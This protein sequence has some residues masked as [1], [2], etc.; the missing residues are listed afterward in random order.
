MNANNVAHISNTRSACLVTR[1][2]DLDSNHCWHQVAGSLLSHE[3][4]R[5][6]RW[7]DRIF[8]RELATRT[9]LSALCCWIW[10]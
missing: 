3:Y 1:I 6:I 4:Q 8:N 9:A 10:L 7:R 2:R 5:H